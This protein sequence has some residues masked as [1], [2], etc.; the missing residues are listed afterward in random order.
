IAGLHVERKALAVV[1]G[2]AVSGSD[3]LALLGFFLG[4]VGDDDPADF[5]FAFLDALDNDAVVQRSDVHLYAPSGV[6]LWVPLVCGR[7]D[8]ACRNTS[9]EA[10]ALAA[11]DC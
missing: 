1:L 4:G 11:S 3:D 6:R 8:P 5:L 2:L 7:D 10:L 9:R